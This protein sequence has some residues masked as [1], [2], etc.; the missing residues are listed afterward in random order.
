M[1]AIGFLEGG[2][3]RRTD[4]LIDLDLPAPEPGP[5]D[6]LVRVE[7]VS[8]NPIDARL[9]AGGKPPVGKPIVLGFD[10]AG[11]VAA[12]GA[13]VSLFAPGDEVFYAG[14]VRRP[15]TNAQLHAVDERLVGPKPRSLGWGEAAALPLT[16]LTAWEL[17][18]DR[19][20][21]P[22]GSGAQGRTLLVVNGAGGVGSILV[23]LARQLTGLTVIASASRP[24]SAAWVRRMGAH[25]VV[26]HRRPLP[27]ELSRIG[28]R[29]V[30]HVASLAGSGANLAVFPKIIAPQGSLAL[31]DD[32]ATFD[33][34]GLRQKSI[35]VAWQGVFTR[36][37]YET[38]DMIAQHRILA[39][40]AGLMDAGTLRTT[41]GRECGP[42]DAAN[43]M[44]AHAL[45][46]SGGTIGKIVLT[47]FPAAAA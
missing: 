38:P 45:I 21:V 27:D 19:L 44:A 10:A 16:A 2:A 37:I 47:G 46:E 13:E 42:I 32:P 8:V 23:Q 34:T 30:D 17:L 18:F 5:R 41:F 15:G 3:I 39:E 22:R 14:T 6:L 26:D 43:L 12:V 20:R 33:I 24:E 7:A 25:H 35:T 40:I 9:R 36:S 4:A 11:T 31:I 29:S 1:R 28:I